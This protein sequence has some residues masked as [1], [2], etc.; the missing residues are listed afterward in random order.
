MVNVESGFRIHW[1]FDFDGTLFDTNEALIQAYEAAI[2]DAGGSLTLGAREMI[3]EGESYV[4][5][6]QCCEWNGRVPDFSEIRLAKS[7]HYNNFFY[8]IKPNEK[9]LRLALDLAPNVSIVTSS[10]RHQVNAVLKYFNLEEEFPS[11]ISADDVEFVKP[12]PELY[13]L[14]QSRNVADLHIAVE[15]SKIGF[16]SASLAGC[17]V[18]RTDNFPF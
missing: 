7:S 2:C 3:K 12:S 14:S 4:R 8:L 17:L 6:L 13:L 11:I 1:N 18:F 9:L 5:F 16:T 15:D 10:R